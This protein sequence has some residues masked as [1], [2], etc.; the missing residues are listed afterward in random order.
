M[1]ASAFM[2]AMLG[3]MLATTT[4]LPEYSI[5]KV[6]EMVGYKDDGNDTQMPLRS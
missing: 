5:D 3:G 6:C 1:G 2:V 4:I